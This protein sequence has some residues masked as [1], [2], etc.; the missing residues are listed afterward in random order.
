M[1]LSGEVVPEPEGLTASIQADL[2]IGHTTATL[3]A[4][5]ENQDGQNVIVLS[6]AGKTDGAVLLSKGPFSEPAAALLRKGKASYSLSG[7]VPAPLANPGDLG[8]WLANTFWVEGQV[9]LDQVQS[10]FVPETVSGDIDWRIDG[11]GETLTVALPQLVGLSITA[12]PP[13]RIAA[14]GL[15]LPPGQPLN[16]QIQPS[17][18]KFDLVDGSITGAWTAD[19]ALNA[20]MAGA[21]VMLSVSAEAEANGSTIQFHQATLEAKSVAFSKDGNAGALDQ[22]K[23]EIKSSIADFKSLK[24]DGKI[25]LSASKITSP[26]VTLAHFQASSPIVVT[27]TLEQVQFTADGLTASGEELELPGKVRLS[28]LFSASAPVLQWDGRKGRATLVIDKGDAAITAAG[29]KPITAAWSQVQADVEGGLSTSGEPEIDGTIAVKGA[30]TTVPSAGIRIDQAELTLPLL[31]GPLAVSGRITDRQRTK[32]FTPINLSLDGTK[33]A[34]DVT[35]TG[36]A[37]LDRGRARVPLRIK[38]NLGTQKIHASYGPAKLEFGDDRLQ[39]ENL[40]PALKIIQQMLGTMTLSGVAAIDPGRAPR[41]NATIVFDDLSVTTDGVKAEG[42]NGKL[43][44]ASL[45][46]LASAG[47]QTLSLRRI[48]VGVPLDDV[49]ARFTIP[50][51]KNGLTVELGE[52]SAALAGGKIRARDVVLRDGSG[53]LLVEVLSLPLERLLEEWKVEGLEG[54]GLISGAIPVSLR[55][56]RVE[57]NDGKLD[58]QRPGVVRVDFGSARETLTSAGEQVELAV[59]TLE[60]FHYR[61]LSIGVDMPSDG[62]LTLAIGLDGNNPAVLEG[63]PF[64]FNINL[65]GKVESILDAIQSGERISADFLQGGLGT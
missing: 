39:P 53:E 28:G 52:V 55:N 13:E 37:S 56:S 42:L 36:R 12:I 51:R 65:S 25:S 20:K 54:T 34:D 44:L 3:N 59:R 33:D 61:E 41:L 60:D 1:K 29:S 43:K 31:A 35:L 26:S 9:S 7:R 19:A 10:A 50:R 47:E 14:A 2:D 5:T 23:A 46:P 32:R 16:V 24:L 38:A 27:G 63:Y 40:S 22:L 21:S 57:I 17:E 62:E 49:A 4:S 58:G 64:R 15:D 30:S 6:G 8:A 48:V 11:D 18:A 45:Q